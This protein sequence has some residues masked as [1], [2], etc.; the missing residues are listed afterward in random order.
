MDER[1]L[2]TVLGVGAALVIAIALFDVATSGDGGG[3]VLLTTTTTSTT[4]P[5]TTSSTAGEPTTTTL[6]KATSDRL[7]QSAARTAL[8]AMKVTYADAGSYSDDPPTLTGVDP[9][10]IFIEG[11]ATVAS[12]TD[13]VYV[14]AG[15]DGQ[16]ACAS[17]RSTS[18]ELFLLKDIAQGAAAGISYARG[19]TLPTRCDGEA[20]APSW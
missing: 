11:I 2:Y 20:L 15:A 4:T 5:A 3:G 13:A 10:I 1:R 14:E 8:V 12:R 19:A 7:A 9:T 16:V 6:D 18:G 17:V